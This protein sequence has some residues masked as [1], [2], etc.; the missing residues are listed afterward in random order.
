[1]TVR[2]TRTLTGGTRVAEKIGLLKDYLPRVM[3]ENKALYSI[4]SK[5]VHELSEEECLESYGLMKATIETILEEILVR[6][7][8]KIRE[9]AIRKEMALLQE[10]LKSDA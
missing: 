3:S 5:G 8:K 7:E 1:M 2:S 10:K 4:L 6:R 9:E